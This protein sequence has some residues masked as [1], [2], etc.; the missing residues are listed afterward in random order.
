MLD[1]AG[2]RALYPEFAKASSDLVQSRLDQATNRY[3][4]DVWAER[5]DE[6]HGLQTAH[7]LA[8]SPFGQAARLVSEK[9]RSTYL[10]EYE[11]ILP[12]VAGLIFRVV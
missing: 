2:F 6:A 12:E 5:S 4:P 9:G 8:I 10:V 7:L 11:R 3:D 1:L